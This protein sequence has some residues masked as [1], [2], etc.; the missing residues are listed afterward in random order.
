MQVIMVPYS[1]QHQSKFR[2]VS[3]N[4]G[5]GICFAIRVQSQ[6][7][8]LFFFFLNLVTIFLNLRHFPG[9]GRSDVR[10]RGDAHFSF[11]LCCLGANLE[12]SIVIDLLGN[13][14]FYIL[15]TVYN[16]FNI[17]TNKH[18]YDYEHICFPH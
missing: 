2:Y 3:G 11:R 10:T 16:F 12:K 7:V 9:F 8:S 13:L 6:D 1:N 14:I 5:P 18:I 15:N 4:R 17:H